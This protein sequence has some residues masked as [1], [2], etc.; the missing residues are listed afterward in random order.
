M[1]YKIRHELHVNPEKSCKSCKR[2]PL[3]S[4]ARDENL[5]LNKVDRNLVGNNAPLVPFI[6]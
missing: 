5:A 1:I 3:K 4:Y 6:Q 2:L